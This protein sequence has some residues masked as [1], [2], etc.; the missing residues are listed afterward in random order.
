MTRG[1][2]RHAAVSGIAMALVCN[3]AVSQ[4]PRRPSS[5]FGDPYATPQATPQTIPLSQTPP[6]S[7]QS[8]QTPLIT[9]VPALPQPSQRTGQ[10]QPS[11]AKPAATQTV[12][13]LWFSKFI[14]NL[15]PGNAA[16][17]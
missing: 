3:V 1:L 7:A 17:S 10:P 11:L 15:N 2:W 4:D 8:V 6:T 12:E 14:I 5:L 16:Q 9:N 13:T